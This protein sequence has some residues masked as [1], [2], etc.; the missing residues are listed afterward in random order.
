MND[1]IWTII[2]Q[3]GTKTRLFSFITSETAKT[4]WNNILNEYK[5]L[6]GKAFPTECG[7]GYTFGRGRG[8]VSVSITKHKILG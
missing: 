1:T 3:K 4:H 2:T 8:R 6:E 5:D 7:M